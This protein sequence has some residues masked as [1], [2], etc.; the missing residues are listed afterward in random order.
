MIRAIMR[1][2][3]GFQKKHILDIVARPFWQHCYTILDSEAIKGPEDMVKYH[4]THVLDLLTENLRDLPDENS[5]EIGARHLMVLSEHESALQI[6]QDKGIIAS[7]RA[8]I[9]YGSYFPED[10]STINLYRHITTIKN[11][12]ETGQ[13]AVLLHLDDIYESLYDM[14][15]QNYTPGVSGGQF[16]RLAIGA[17]SRQCEVNPNFRCAMARAALLTNHVK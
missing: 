3:G 15:N 6:L 5:H 4:G 8:K 9:I 13:T 14:L 7:S 10:R 11:C 1:S 17:R 12:M 2:F 16:C